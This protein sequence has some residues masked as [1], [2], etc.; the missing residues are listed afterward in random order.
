MKQNPNTIYL[1]ILF[2]II[3]TFSIGCL[4]NDLVKSGSAEKARLLYQNSLLPTDTILENRHKIKQVFK[5]MRR[6]TFDTSRTSIFDKIKDYDLETEWDI[7]DSILQEFYV[8]MDFNNNPDTPENEWMIEMKH[9]MDYCDAHF[10][11]WWTNNDMRAYV[12]IQLGT[13]DLY[14]S[15]PFTTRC[16][17]P[18]GSIDS[19]L[20]CEQCQLTYAKRNIYIQLQGKFGLEYFTEVVA[21]YDTGTSRGDEFSAS[22][23]IIKAQSFFLDNVIVREEKPYY[24]PIPEAKKEL[25]LATNVFIQPVNKNN[26]EVWSL[27]ALP[28]SQFSEDSNQYINFHID[29]KIW[30]LGHS[31]EIYAHNQSREYSISAHM[32]FKDACCFFAIYNLLP[33]GDWSLVSTPIEDGTPNKTI[34]SQEI[35]LPPLMQSD[36]LSNILLYFRNASEKAGSD[37]VLINNEYYTASPFRT[38]HRRDSLH[39]LVT[40]PDYEAGESVVVWYLSPRKEWTYQ[41]DYTA[42][43][44]KFWTAMR[45]F[46]F[47]VLEFMEESDIVLSAEKLV[48]SNLYRLNTSLQEIPK[49]EYSLNFL[50]VE[51]RL[52]KPAQAVQVNL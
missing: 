3:L 17:H 26:Y 29:Q 30:Q 8:Q 45:K 33:R 51:P 13:D 39:A 52:K 32:D 22:Q 46:D 6:S 23:N 2:C 37:Q 36:E 44:E 28:L 50:L 25:K 5:I 12:V 35:A 24:E 47:P 34:Y 27:Y 41:K 31:P 10:H 14:C 40:W 48:N 11:G 21:Y 15:V 1:G 38:Y 18:D 20:L 42:Y 9:R 16:V 19:F 49:G 4:S 7:I 43:S